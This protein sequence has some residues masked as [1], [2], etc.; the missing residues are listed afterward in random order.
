MVKPPVSAWRVSEKCV[1]EVTMSTLLSRPPFRDSLAPDTISASYPP[2]TLSHLL[3]VTA[4]VAL[5]FTT[6]RPLRLEGSTNSAEFTSS[7][8]TCAC[9]DGAPTPRDRPNSAQ[10]QRRAG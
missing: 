5:G 10:S 8:A 4:S 1:A 7:V 3:G 9:A 6:V 2:C